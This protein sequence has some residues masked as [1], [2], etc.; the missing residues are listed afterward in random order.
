M[1]SN[2][3]LGLLVS[4]L[5]TISLTEPVEPSNVLLE[6]QPVSATIETHED[7]PVP[8]TTFPLPIVTEPPGVKGEAQA[9]EAVKKRHGRPSSVRI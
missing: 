4:P 5:T 6:S 9:C 3:P 7:T 8:E 2:P 1:K